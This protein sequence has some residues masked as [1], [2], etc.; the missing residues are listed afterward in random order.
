MNEEGLFHHAFQF[1]WIIRTNKC[2]SNN[3]EMD[4]DDHV[5]DNTKYVD[6]AEDCIE[7]AQCVIMANVISSE[8][9]PDLRSFLKYKSCNSSH[10]KNCKYLLLPFKAG[11]A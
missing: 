2:S 8:A 6:L 9:G 1:L 4:E 7:A 3:I 5:P 10:C 11:M